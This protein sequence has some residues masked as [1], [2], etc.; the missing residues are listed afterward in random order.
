MRTLSELFYYTVETYRKPDHLLRK[1]DGVWVPMSSDALAAAV[2]EFSMGLRSL[3][4]EKGD[5]VAILS[6]NRPEWLVADL[7]TLCLGGISVPA[8][9]TLPAAQIRHI[10]ADSE[11]RL[12]VVSNETQARKI[13][14][15]KSGLPWLRHVVR[16]DP[17]VPGGSLALDEVRARGREALSTDRLA[18]KRR[19]DEVQ[20]DDIA[21]LIYTSGTTGEPKGVMLSHANILANLRGAALAF[22]LIGRTDLALSFLPLS[23]AFERTVTYFWLR[24]GAGIAFAESVERVPD[25]LQELRPTVMCSVPRLYEKIYARVQ[26]NVAAGSPISRKIFAWAMRVGRDTFRCRLEKRELG[27]VLR[28]KRA[29]ADVL[30]FRKIWARTGGRMKLFVSGGAPLAREIAEFLGAV[31]FTVCEGYGLTETSPVISAN[32]PDRMRPG[33]VGLPLEGV[34]VRIAQ[35]GEILTRGP[36]VM[37]GY[38]RKPEATSEMIDKDGW[39]H[40]GDIGLLD[41]DG[42][43]VITDRKKD[44]I[45]TSGGK[46][47]APQPVENRLK[48]DAFIQEV[49]MIGNRRS[50]AT[51]LVV[52]AFLVLEKWATENGVTFTDRESLVASPVV[53]DFLLKR[54]ASLTA[55]LATFEKIKRIALLPREFSLETG[56]LTPTLKVKRRVVEERY[57]DMVEKLYEGPAS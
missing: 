10:L 35:D 41:A 51:A 24:V 12:V 17:P 34:E 2:E 56:E 52:P 4:V 8:Y 27:L 7:A 28:A 39:L 13:D 50:F 44:I 45:V 47:I 36:H 49:V 43:L 15:I 48:T 23:H 37:K 57:K 55:D 19:A 9:A 22:P 31:G 11:A 20:P 3:G 5:R 18:V 46:N 1:K 14:E 40:T 38:F 32:R 33:S 6:E 25:N 42:F 16:M 53:V 54:I 29:L 26:E 30:V 21:T